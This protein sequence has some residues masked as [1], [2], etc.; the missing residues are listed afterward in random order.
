MPE[1]NGSQRTKNQIHKALK[2]GRVEDIWPGATFEDHCHW[3]RVYFPDGSSVK[4]N[5]ASH[6]KG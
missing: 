5:F 2:D 6:Y 4:I 1:I 3:G